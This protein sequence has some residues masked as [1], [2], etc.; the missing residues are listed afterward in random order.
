MAEQF[1]EQAPS[2]SAVSKWLRSMV[3]P[4][5]QYGEILAAVLG[6]RPA[7][8]YFNDGPMTAGQ[9]GQ[10]ISGTADEVLAALEDQKPK[11]RHRTG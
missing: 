9:G 10:T 1:G 3:P 4:E 6:V 8:L 11:R 7:W 5:P 2:R